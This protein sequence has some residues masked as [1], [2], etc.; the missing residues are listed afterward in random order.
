MH[1]LLQSLG[2][3]KCSHM[4]GNCVRISCNE[5]LSCSNH[6]VALV[7]PPFDKYVTGFYVNVQHCVCNAVELLWFD[8]LVCLIEC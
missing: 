8:W 4:D 1:S 5:R 6:A 7:L 3:H 2:L